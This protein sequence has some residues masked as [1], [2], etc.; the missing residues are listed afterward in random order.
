MKCLLDELSQ[1]KR[2]FVFIS[3]NSVAAFQ[4]DVTRCRPSSTQH[5]RFFYFL[6]LRASQK[7]T[8]L[9][10]PILCRVG[11]KTI[12]QWILSKLQFRSVFCCVLSIGPV[13]SRK[14]AKINA[15]NQRSSSD[16]QLVP[17]RHINSGIAAA[18]RSAAKPPNQRPVFR[19]NVRRQKQL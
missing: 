5:E 1:N 16:A 14:S 11:R 12:A 19:A 15:A 7:R 4:L 2:D 9:K 3:V 17:V 10:W 18:K 13:T 6:N 8:S